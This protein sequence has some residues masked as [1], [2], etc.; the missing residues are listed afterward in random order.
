MLILILF[1]VFD[2]CKY[3]QKLGTTNVVELFY[4]FPRMELH[5]G[6]CPFKED[7]YVR[8]LHDW[9][10]FALERLMHIY[11]KHIEEG[12]KEQVNEVQGNEGDD[13]HEL[14]KMMKGLE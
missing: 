11:V 10:E 13:E 3:A 8:A 6:L 4:Q 9:L 14:K 12:D 2:M 5:N 1:V 7:G